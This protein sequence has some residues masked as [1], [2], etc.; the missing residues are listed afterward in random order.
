[1]GLK[2]RIVS[3]GHKAQEPAMAVS[4]AAQ[5]YSKATHEG[6]HPS[7]AIGAAAVARVYAVGA[8]NML[9]NY[10]APDGPSPADF[11]EPRDITNTPSG[12]EVRWGRR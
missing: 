3:M 2:D 7:V 4:A 1:M 9:E 10:D 12:V 8:N 5:A 6:Y 11:H